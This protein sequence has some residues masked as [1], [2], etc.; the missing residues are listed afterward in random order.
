M[1]EAEWRRQGFLAMPTPI[2]M[3]QVWYGCCQPCGERLVNKSMGASKR[4]AMV[5]VGAA[6]AFAL[7]WRV[8]LYITG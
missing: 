2:Q 1:T 7:I 6:I 3:R 4:I 5:A 8:T